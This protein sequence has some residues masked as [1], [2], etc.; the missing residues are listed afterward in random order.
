MDFS[1]G[2]QVSH[3]GHLDS[4]QQSVTNRREVLERS[5]YASD[6]PFFK[7]KCRF[8]HKVFGSDSALQIHVRSHTADAAL[9]WGWKGTVPNSQT[10]RFPLC[11]QVKLLAVA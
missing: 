4:G 1:L 9:A 11:G 10:R 3:F 6:D 7:H 2:L 5:Q 8:C